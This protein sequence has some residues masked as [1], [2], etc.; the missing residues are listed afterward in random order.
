MKKNNKFVTWNMDWINI[1]ESPWGIFEKFKYANSASVK[2]IFCLFGIQQVQE[3]KT[4][5]GKYHRDLFTLNGINDELVKSFLGF[6][7]KSKNKENLK[8]IGWLL[9]KDTSGIRKYFNSNLV[10]CEKC[11]AISFHSMMHQ[12]ILLKKCPF[13]MVELIEECPWCKRKIPYVLSDDYTKSP[14]QCLCGY[15]LIDKKNDT[16]VFLSWKKKSEFRINDPLVKKWIILNGDKKRQIYFFYEFYQQ[17]EFNLLENLISVLSPS[18]IKYDAPSS[19]FH[20][21][22]N[23]STEKIFYPSNELLYEKMYKSTY[24]TYK[25]FARFLKK[26]LLKDHK[27]CIARLKKRAPDTKIC[28]YAYAFLHWRK[29]IEGLNHYSDVENKR[30]LKNPSIINPCLEFVFR[31]DNTHLNKISLEI[32]KNFKETISDQQL[33]WAI[34]KIMYIIVHNH[35][36]NWLIISEELASHNLMVNHVPFGYENIP[37]F[38]LHLHQTEGKEIKFTFGEN[39]YKNGITHKL[40][41][42]FSSVKQRRKSNVKYSHIFFKQ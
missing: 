21:S 38:M 10:Y 7:I 31:Q 6:S 20:F 28:P 29:S 4:T 33:I 26:T 14:F 13:H 35:F 8:K 41:C 3:I 36:F 2:D 25:S 18:I 40:K 27:T 24:Q 39:L 42:P 34:N 1:F 37:F 16:S 15:S 19:N 22:Y 32:K 17:S 30:K 9:A 5:P 11:M 12:F 23:H